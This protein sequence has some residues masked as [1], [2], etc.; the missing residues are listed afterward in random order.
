MSASFVSVY[1]WRYEIDCQF[2]LLLSISMAIWE[3]LPIVL[4]LSISMEICNS[5]SA[6]F[7]EYIYGDMSM[8]VSFCCWVY[9]WRYENNFQ[10]LV[11]LWR[12]ENDCLTIQY[13]HVLPQ[14]LLSQLQNRDSRTNCFLNIKN[15][16]WDPLKTMKTFI[17][18]KMGHTT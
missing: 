5:S 11:Y 13:L 7:V 1:L 6:Y 2:L 15:Q 10:F 12:F 16:K 18:K 4:L 14:L 3:W 8:I 17:R 9:L